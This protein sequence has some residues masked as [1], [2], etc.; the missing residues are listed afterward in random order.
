V[1][2]LLRGRLT[3]VSSA[4]GDAEAPAVAINSRGQAAVAFTEWHDRHL[5]LRVATN[6]GPRW[7]TAT[8]DDSVLPIWTPR[9]AITATGTMTAAWIDDEGWWRRLRAAVRKGGRWQPPVTLESGQGLGALALRA[10]RRV[11]VATWPDS[12]GSLF[13]V[14]AV[15]F[16]GESLRRAATLTSG[17][18][19]IAAVRIDPGDL[20]IHWQ[21]ASS[22][23]A[24]AAPWQDQRWGTPVPASARPTPGRPRTCT[25]RRGE[26]LSNKQRKLH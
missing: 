16:D 18:A 9:V 3:T 23:L 1:R 12:A 11:T 6:D 25:R 19:R 5:R 4:G 26:G 21:D 8:L 13:R 24:Y 2:V 7:H 15:A 14:R 22:G 20:S 17:F 10:V